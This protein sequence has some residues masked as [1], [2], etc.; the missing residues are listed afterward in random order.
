MPGRELGRGWAGNVYTGDDGI[1]EV[2]GRLLR[3]GL[4]VE[5]LRMTAK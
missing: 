5:R 3:L 1:F 4:I 2:A